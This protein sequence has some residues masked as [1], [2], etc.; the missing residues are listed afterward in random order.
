M[1]LKVKPYR[2]QYYSRILDIK[3]KQLLNVQTLQIIVLPHNID[4]ILIHPIFVTNETCEEG[5]TS[6]GRFHLYG[7]ESRIVDGC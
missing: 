4:N 6:L 1:L 2:Q 3:V 5:E 7:S